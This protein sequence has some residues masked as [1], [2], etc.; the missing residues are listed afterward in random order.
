MLLR[1]KKFILD[2]LVSNPRPA[3]GNGSSTDTRFCTEQH[4]LLVL[5]NAV[6]VSLMYQD[7][8]KKNCT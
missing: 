4:V 1:I 6:Y 3:T 7:S 2:Y 8:N 5:L